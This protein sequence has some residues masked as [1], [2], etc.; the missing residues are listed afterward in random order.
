V[1]G[2][3]S[4]SSAYSWQSLNGIGANLCDLSIVLR[5]YAR[6]ADAADNLAIDHDWDTAFHEIDIWHGEVPQSRAAPEQRVNSRLFMCEW[7]PPGKRKC[8]V[9][10]R[11][12]LQSCVRPVHA[13]RMDCW[14]SWSPRTEASSLERDRCPNETVIG[15]SSCSEWP[16]TIFSGQT[17]SSVAAS[18]PCRAV[19]DAR[20]ADP[21]SS[22]NCACTAERRQRLTKLFTR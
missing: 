22:T 19:L 8:S 2:W 20:R 16:Q 4:R 12:R 15:A 13:V 1:L 3:S 17:S 14:P 9:P 5:I 21:R 11:S 7:P 10:H 18:Y 6:Y